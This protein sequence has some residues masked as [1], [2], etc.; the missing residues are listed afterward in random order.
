M[1]RPEGPRR[2]SHRI[3]CGALRRPTYAHPNSRASAFDCSANFRALAFR[4]RSKFWSFHRRPGSCSKCGTP[5]SDH[6]GSAA[7]SDSR[8]RRSSAFRPC[9]SSRIIRSRAAKSA[10]SS[11]GSV[12]MPAK[13]CSNS[14]RRSRSDGNR[15]SCTVAHEQVD[16]RA[17]LE[18]ERIVDEHQRR[19]ARQQPR[20][21]EVDLV[22]GF[23]TRSPSAER[24][25]QALA[26]PLGS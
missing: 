6:S 3:T 13:L 24:D 8:K 21:V 20:A 4:S 7:T 25:T 1:G 10:S 26:L 9:C 14:W 16:R 2:Q 18:C 22:H 15:T 5:S 12:V 19:H 11:T 23:S 17:A